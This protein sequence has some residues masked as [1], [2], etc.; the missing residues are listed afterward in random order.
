MVT[1]SPRYIRSRVMLRQISLNR[2]MDSLK[3]APNRRRT[4][5]KITH[6]NK[7][8]RNKDMLSRRHILSKV[9]H[10]LKRGSPCM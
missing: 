8:I 3:M 5:S 9:T 1:R 4:R 7:R 10:S 2:A 6:N